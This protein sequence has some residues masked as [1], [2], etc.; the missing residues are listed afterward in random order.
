MAK[1]TEETPAIAVKKVIVV[2]LP[3]DL[4]ERL[5]A[6]PFLHALRDHYQDAELHFI[7]PKKYIE[8][9]NLLPFTAFYHEYDED[10]I[11]NVLDVHRYC[12]QVKIYN[13]DLFIS[14]TN[15]FSDAC[16]GL[17]LRAKK[18]LGF[19]DGWKTLVL[20]EKTL[21]PVGHHLCEDFFALYKLH[22]GT[23]VDPRSRVTARELAPVVEQWDSEPYIAINIAPFRSVTLEQE[24]LELLNQ[25]EGQRL[26]LFDSEEQ[27]ATGHL[28]KPFL[29]RLPTTNQYSYF[30][31][32]DWIE[33][34][35]LLT[36]ARGVI[37]YNGPLATLSAYTGSKTLVLFDREDPQRT[38]PYY[39]MAEV[40]HVAQPRPEN[41]AHLSSRVPF[42][43][44]PVASKAHAFFRL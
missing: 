4:Q 23:D 14:L 26:I 32:K 37:T 24:W 41:S 13:V 31:Y 9:L 29:E 20:N 22:T 18:R 3:F 19:A 28:I 36:Y 33:L 43:M 6:F 8:V 11:Q 5:L 39:F 10:E 44:D 30:V 40:M 17:G 25:F 7:T 34:A 15:S 38:G 16:L 21:R 35:K 42:D 1:P 12:A 27:D 2:K